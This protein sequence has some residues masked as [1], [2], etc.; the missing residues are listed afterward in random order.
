MPILG[1]R[2][3]ADQQMDPMPITPEALP[4][5]G[6]VFTAY[7]DGKLSG[8]E[9]TYDSLEDMQTRLLLRLQEGWDTRHQP[10]TIA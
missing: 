6:T 2:I 3:L 8:G 1:W 10:K 9:D 7:P 5:N 4:S